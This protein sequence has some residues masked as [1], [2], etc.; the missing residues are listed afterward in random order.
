[1]EPEWSICFSPLLL[2]YAEIGINVCAG[3]RCQRCR[4]CHRVVHRWP[5]HTGRNGIKHKWYVI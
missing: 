1:M 3:A 5:T 4:H 2:L